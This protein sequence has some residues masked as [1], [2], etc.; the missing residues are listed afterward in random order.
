MTLSKLPVKTTLSAGGVVYRRHA[1]SI[2]VV[3][4]GQKERGL[5]VLP[6]GQVEKGEDHLA[7]AVREVAEETG[8]QVKPVAELGAIDYWFVD[9]VEA[10]R[11][12]KTVYFFLMECTGGDLSRHDWEY[13]QVGW[14]SPAD[15]L[16]AM[17]HKNEADLLRKALL[18]FSEHA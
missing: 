6:K 2:D 14:F 17:S 16:A 9:R 7:T 4:V 8:L 18:R 11:V 15:A 13:D 5:W 10:M 12:H 3:L 1:G